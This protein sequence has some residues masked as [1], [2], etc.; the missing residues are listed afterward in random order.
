MLHAETENLVELARGRP[1]P[2]LREREIGEA[3]QV[4]RDSFA[5]LDQDRESV[6][7]VRDL[8]IAGSGG[9]QLGLRAYWPSSRT[10]DDV[11]LFFHG[12]GWTFGD[13]ESH[14]GFCRTL[15]NKLGLRVVSVDYRLAPEH[16][17]PAAHLDGAAALDWLQG[18]PGELGEAVS[19]IVLAGDSAGGNIAAGLAAACQPNDLLRAQLLFYPVL[20]VAQQSASYR[21]FGEGYLLE[22]N[23]MAWFIDAYIPD[24]GAREDPCV[25]PLRAA[26]EALPPT[27]IVTAGCDVLRDE[28]RAY[29]ARLARLGVDCHFIEARGFTHNWATSRRVLPSAVPFLTRAIDCLRLFLSP[30]L[31]QTRS[32]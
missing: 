4:V 8:I 22:A 25:S 24:I 26:F 13:L 17:F 11:L 20:D 12:G 31:R 29:A 10:T 18:S 9:G 16:V 3:R 30:P 27:I 5:A 23:D 1:G 32:A 7:G 14:D 21:E 15:T 2:K 19:G 6:A 28:G